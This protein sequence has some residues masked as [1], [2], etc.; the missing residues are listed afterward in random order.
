MADTIG[1]FNEREG[2]YPFL[3]LTKG[4]FKETFAGVHSAEEYPGT[5]K[6]S[7]NVRDGS[8]K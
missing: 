2:S 6:Y 1:I 7:E 3:N 4:V 5:N 8:S